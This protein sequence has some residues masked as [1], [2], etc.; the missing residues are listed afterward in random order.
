[1]KNKNIFRITENDLHNMIMKSVKRMLKENNEPDDSN[2]D[3]AE[4]FANSDLSYQLDDKQEGLGEHVN[5]ML[6][7]AFPE[8][9]EIDV[10][11]YDESKPE[12]ENGWN[13]G[14][15]VSYSISER[16]ANTLYQMF[17]QDFAE[18]LIDMVDQAAENR[19][20]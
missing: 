16:D 14:Y 7:K 8:G 6:T 10:D 5:D 11:I 20:N 15:K 9:V 12:P 18:T 13:G 19:A 1:M 3:I 2:I 4:L 17:P